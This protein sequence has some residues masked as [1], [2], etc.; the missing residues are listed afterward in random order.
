MGS[1]MFYLSGE[2]D[3]QMTTINSVN[4]VPA[5]PERIQSNPMLGH[6]AK[7]QGYICLYARFAI[8]PP[9]KPRIAKTMKT[10]ILPAMLSTLLKDEPVY[11]LRVPYSENVPFTKDISD[12]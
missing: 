5:A 1:L 2:N 10:V 6:I 7:I 4:T 8:M 9:T 11:I 3:A 12:L